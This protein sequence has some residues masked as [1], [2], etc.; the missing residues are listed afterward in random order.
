MTTDEIL[1]MSIGELKA[2]D[3]KSLKKLVSRVAD[4]ANKRAER[5]ANKGW[6]TSANRQ[7]ADSG[8]K[9][10]VKG[11][12]TQTQLLREL[13]R[14]RSYLAM[15]TSTIKGAMKQ[16]L[17]MSN[18]FGG[19]LTDEQSNEFWSIYHRLEE[20]YKGKLG[21]GEGLFDSDNVQEML[22]DEVIGEDKSIEDIFENIEDNLKN[23]YED[24]E[25]VSEDFFTI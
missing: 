15:K 7:L 24:F 19:T 1:Q 21:K 20:K 10:S 14:A 13:T 9:I 3:I 17:Y 23:S 22:R 5:L 12:S 11:K 2:L 8:G 16:R 6:L 18:E 4:T 25:D